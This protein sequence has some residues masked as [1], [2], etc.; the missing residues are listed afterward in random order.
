MHTLYYASHCKPVHAREGYSSYVSIIFPSNSVFWLSNCG[1]LLRVVK[2]E[3]WGE[4]SC[5]LF[6]ISKLKQGHNGDEKRVKHLTF[7][8]VINVIGPLQIIDRFLISKYIYRKVIVKFPG[9]Q[10]YWGVCYWY[11]ECRPFLWL[12]ECIGNHVYWNCSGKKLQY[13]QN[14]VLQLFNQLR[15]H[16]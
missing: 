2:G 11:S 16:L 13:S 1:D 9:N 15:H 3:G 8:V 4:V 10:K 14:S 6:I 5:F 12:T 7:N